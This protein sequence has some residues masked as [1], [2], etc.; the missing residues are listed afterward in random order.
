MEGVSLYS[1][2]TE[3]V[4]GASKIGTEASL[5]TREAGSVGFVEIEAVCSL[6]LDEHCKYGPISS[7]ETFVICDCSS[8]GKLSCTHSSVVRVGVW[9]PL[10][11]NIWCSS[12]SFC[13]ICQSKCVSVC[14]SLPGK[15]LSAV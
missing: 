9:V 12:K 6:F 4:G 5:Y 10:P 2:E 3:P 13:C 8:F 1:R 15:V 11:L 14:D 7:G